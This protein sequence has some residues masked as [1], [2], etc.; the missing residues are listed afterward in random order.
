MAEESFPAA[1]AAATSGAGVALA[2]VAF[3]GAAAESFLSAAVVWSAAA[4]VDCAETPG[5]AVPVASS[6][7]A[8]IDAGVGAR[9]LEF[10]LRF[11]V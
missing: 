2:G 6:A 1:S 5:L 9:P 8:A 4:G 7:D 11:R 3:A 10:G